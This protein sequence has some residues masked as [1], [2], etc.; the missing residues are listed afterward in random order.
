[1]RDDKALSRRHARVPF[2]EKSANLIRPIC[3]FAA[4]RELRALARESTPPPA[5]VQLASPGRGLTPRKESL[6]LSLSL[7][8]CFE[9]SIRVRIRAA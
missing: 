8:L 5:E 6:S 3:N 1:M 7:S 2:A 9:S 4:S